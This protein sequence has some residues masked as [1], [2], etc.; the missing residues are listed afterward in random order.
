MAKRQKVTIQKDTSGKSNFPNVN[1]PSEDEKEM[2][3]NTNG[4]PSYPYT[5]PPPMKE[6]SEQNPEYYKGIVLRLNYGET[7]VG[8]QAIDILDALFDD[9]PHLWNAGKYLLRNGKKVSEKEITGLKKAIWYQIHNL[10]K[11]GISEEEI[12]KDCFKN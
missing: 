1:Q 5:P 12:I 7:A 11:L 2:A 4:L 8:V 6:N 10:R 3:I 9:N